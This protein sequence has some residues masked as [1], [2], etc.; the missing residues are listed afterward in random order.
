M[1]ASPWPRARRTVASVE[2]LRSRPF[3]I[4][5]RRSALL[6]AGQVALVLR[7]YG[8]GGAGELPSIA[9]PALELA[10]EALAAGSDGS[11]TRDEL[12]RLA[13]AVSGAAIALLWER[14]AGDELV[15][16]SSHGLPEPPPKLGGARVVAARAL[17]GLGPVDVTTD[18]L[19]PP[20]GGLPPGR[21]LP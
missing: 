12:T 2:L 20:V 18:G 4:D 15:L 9:I 10:G 5:E 1:P 13:A 3:G 19:L 7:A 16:V 14:T 11:R 21:S 6:A 17:A 8:V